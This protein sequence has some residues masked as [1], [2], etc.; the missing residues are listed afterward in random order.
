MIIGIT[1]GIASGKSFVVSILEKLEGPS[2][3]YVIDADEV[4]HSLIS[5]GAPLVALLAGEFGPGILSPEGGIDRKKLGA[6]VF[7]SGAARETLNGL[8]HPAVI[9]EI[10]NL[11]AAH[12]DRHI[13]L[14]APLLIESGLIP[15]VDE[16]WLVAVNEKKQVERLMNRE[17]IT[18]ED[19]LRRMASQMP[20]EEKK[21]FADR[22]I[23][24]DGPA[25]ETERAVKAL[26]K[27]VVEGKLPHGT[28]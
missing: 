13:V 18:E 7:S 2:C 27:E 1:G 21:R 11:L 3:P 12:R 20:L 22:V 16:L 9:R 15:L 25:G 28:H 24:N 19:A 4:Y 14:A 10:Q 23:D 6:L 8:T 26:W 5:P 17:H